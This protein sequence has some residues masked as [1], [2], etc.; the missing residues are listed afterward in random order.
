MIEELEE[1]E[2]QRLRHSRIILYDLLNSVDGEAILPNLHVNSGTWS[3]IRR[4]YRYRRHRLSVKV[5]H[6]VICV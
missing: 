2:A 6:V 3:A 4:D 5:R 1:D